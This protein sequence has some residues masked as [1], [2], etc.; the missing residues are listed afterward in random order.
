MKKK[1]EVVYK[2]K[3]KIPKEL[4]VFF[5]PDTKVELVKKGYALGITPNNITAMPHPKAKE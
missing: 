5:R 3:P 4:L 2:K 1:F